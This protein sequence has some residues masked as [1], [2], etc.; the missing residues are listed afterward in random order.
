MKNIFHVIG[1][2]LLLS[3]CY[4]DPSKL[5]HLWMETYSEHSQGFSTPTFKKEKG[6]I[7][8]F[9]NDTLTRKIFFFEFPEDMS[10]LRDRVY[11]TKR[12]K[13]LTKKYSQPNSW[14]Y[15]IN[16]N[17]LTINYNLIYPGEIKTH[18]AKLPRYNLA[19]KKN[20]FQEFLSSSTFKISD[21]TRIEFREDGELLNQRLLKKDP[22]ATANWEVHIFDGELF[23]AVEAYRG[24]G[25]HVIHVTEFDA[26][27]F[28][29]AIYQR[30]TKET[31][32]NKVS[33]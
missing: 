21:G 31:V 19:G 20:D 3:G 29:G 1:L 16:K 23:I 15:E 28:V 13:I 12:G 4:S 7:I 6:N 11:Q 14:D 27:K 17:D 25:R 30:E 26:E 18:Y 22:Y 2:L 24:A 5:Q 8:K 33:N 9:W 10:D 32:Y